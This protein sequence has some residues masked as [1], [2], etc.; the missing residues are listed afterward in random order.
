VFVKPSA[1]KDAALIVCGLKLNMANRCI[2][3]TKKIEIK[4]RYIFIGLYQK[5]ILESLTD[6][7]FCDP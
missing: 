4:Q 1:S 5:F 3:G 7:T 6:K 2:S